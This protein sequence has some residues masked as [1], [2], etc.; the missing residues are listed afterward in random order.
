MY[1]VFVIYDELV[2]EVWFVYKIEVLKVM[3]ECVGL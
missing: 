3:I 2:G 1:I